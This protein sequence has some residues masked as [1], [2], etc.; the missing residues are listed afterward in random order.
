MQ[1]GDEG[2]GEAQREK[3]FASPSKQ[4]RIPINEMLVM[5]Q[6]MVRK[7]TYRTAELATRIRVTSA[8]QT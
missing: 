3:N 7:S 4:A 1:G 8:A 2:D 5:N 6:H